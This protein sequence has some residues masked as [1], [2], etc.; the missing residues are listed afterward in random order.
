MLSVEG[1]SGG[2]IE[3]C[4]RADCVQVLGG[5]HRRRYDRGQLDLLSRLEPR[6][7]AE[8]AHGLLHLGCSACCG[9]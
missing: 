5:T 2:L 4:E 3:G 8:L 6:F 9:A 1:R 7:C